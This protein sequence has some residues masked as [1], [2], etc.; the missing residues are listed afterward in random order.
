[1]ALYLKL[2]IRGKEKILKKEINCCYMFTF[3]AVLLHVLILC[4]VS[5]YLGGWACFSVSIIMIGVLTMFIQDLATEFGCTVGLKD[6]ITAISVVALGT[7]VPGMSR[8]TT[9][10][11]SMPAV[12]ST[13]ARSMH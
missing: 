7:S 10:F 13:A 3:C 8:K 5:D 6:S 2:N 1:M 11:H 9:P 12:F 4:C